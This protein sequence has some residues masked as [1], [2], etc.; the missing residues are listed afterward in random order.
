MVYSQDSLVEAAKEEASS[1]SNIIAQAT[2]WGF[3]SGKKCLVS[4]AVC[5]SMVS[6]QCYHKFEAALFLV[7]SNFVQV[8]EEVVKL[9]SF[10]II[11]SA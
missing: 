3:I 6:I 10:C 5:N 1:I 8:C 9:K 4:C 7:T 2:K 11:K